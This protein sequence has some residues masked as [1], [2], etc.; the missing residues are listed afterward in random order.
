MKPAGFPQQFWEYMF[1]EALLNT[2]MDYACVSVLS[3]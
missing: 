3:I 1:S 2:F